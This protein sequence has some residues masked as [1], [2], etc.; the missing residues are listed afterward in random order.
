LGTVLFLTALGDDSQAVV[1]KVSEAVS[2]AL[3]EFRLAMEAFG[4]ADVFGEPPHA[5]DGEERFP[6]GCHDP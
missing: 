3:N 6:L 2:S 4:N 1:F 5:G